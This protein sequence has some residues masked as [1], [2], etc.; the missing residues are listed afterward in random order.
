MFLTQSA[1]G[2]L[3]RGIVL[4]S[5]GTADLA[6]TFAEQRP[7]IRTLQQV[8]NVTESEEICPFDPDFIPPVDP[9]LIPPVEPVPSP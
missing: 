1:D 2:P 7:F 9:D 5:C 6:E 8:T 4:Q 3:R